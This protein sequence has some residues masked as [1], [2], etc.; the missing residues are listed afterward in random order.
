MII[1]AAVMIIVAAVMI[2]VAAVMIIVAVITVRIIIMIA[3]DVGM[4]TAV[5]VLLMTTGS[6]GL[7]R[8]WFLPHRP[9]EL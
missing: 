9:V 6:G 2:I 7:G 4:A 3:M 5:G 1:V 8:L